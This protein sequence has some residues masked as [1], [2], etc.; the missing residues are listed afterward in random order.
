MPGAVRTGRWHAVRDI[1]GQR[2]IV[3][4]V[5]NV[6]PDSFSGDGLGGDVSGAGSRPVGFSRRAPRSSTSAARVHGRVMSRCRPG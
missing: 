1:L 4:G 6:T 5:I 2:T 3:M